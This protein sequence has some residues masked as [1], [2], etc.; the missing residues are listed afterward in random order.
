VIGKVITT[1]KITPTLCNKNKDKIFIFG[2]NL[3]RAGMLGQ[4]IIRNCS[5]A[6]GIPTKYK[7][8][9]TDEAYFTDDDKDLFFMIKE[10]FD[11]LELELT[12]GKDIVVPYA[13]IGTGLAKLPEKAPKLYKYIRS[14]LYKLKRISEQGVIL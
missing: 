9:R 12:N 3:E 13:G 10:H 4:A 2:D 6:F 5:N 1:K 11:M 8:T 14:R 7:P